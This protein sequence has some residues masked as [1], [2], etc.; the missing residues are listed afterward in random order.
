VNSGDRTIFH[1]RRSTFSPRIG[2][3]YGLSSKTVIR[4]GYGIF[5]IPNYVSFGLNPLNDMVNA[6][7]TTYSGTIDGTHP[8]NT[9]ALPFP[10]GISA[11]PGRSLG[12][13]GRNNF[14]LKSC[15]RSRRRIPR[16]HPAGMSSNG[17]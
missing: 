9:I 17:I 11:P 5:W 7:T 6:A 1:W 13:Q 14:S 15:S 10:S 2:L 8:V 3:A 12:A 16:N 4:S